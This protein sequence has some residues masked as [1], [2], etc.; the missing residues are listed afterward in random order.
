MN[1]EQVLE[2][3][4]VQIFATDKDRPRFYLHEDFEKVAPRKDFNLGIEP[5]HV[6][7]QAE[8]EAILRLAKPKKGKMTWE[9][10]YAIKTVCDGVGIKL[11]VGYQP[12]MT[13]RE[14]GI[15]TKDLGRVKWVVSR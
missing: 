5:R 2:N 13:K 3:T 1:F 14:E 10:Y 11:L 8:V 15:K 7:N 9:F 12:D 6:F 4:K